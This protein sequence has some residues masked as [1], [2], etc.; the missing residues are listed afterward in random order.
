VTLTQLKVFL[1]VARSGSVK[2]AASTLGV[3]EPAVSGAVAVLRKELGDPLFLR[4]GS[5][6]ELTPGGRRLAATAAEMLGLAAETRRSMGEDEPPRLTVAA[7]PMVAEDVVPWLLDAFTVRQPTVE[8][9]TLAVPASAFVELLRDRRADVTIGP[10]VAGPPVGGL[11]PVESVPF[12]RFAL[13]VVTAPDRARRLHAPITAAQLARQPWLLGPSGADP[14]TIT[15]DFLAALGTEPQAISIF[16]SN[17][18]ALQLAAEGQGLTLAFRH[19]VRPELERGSLAVVDTAV[20]PPH[21][22]LYAS[23]LAT[24]RRSPAAAALCRFMATPT[25]TQAV[26]MHSGGRPAK[27]FKPPVYVTIWS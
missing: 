12:L 18:T 22:M 26:L 2:V 20:A 17:A 3:T 27:Q 7:V 25:A 6:I 21:G 24:D 11:P 5:G 8:T 10:R 13:A 16:P 1:T 23:T 14:G 15:G 4:A 9:G 19:T